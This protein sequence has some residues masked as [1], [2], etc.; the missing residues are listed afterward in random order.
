[1]ESKAAAAVAMFVDANNTDFNHLCLFGQD[2]GQMTRS[3]SAREGFGSAKVRVPPV[4]HGADGA[5][6]AAENH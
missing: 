6:P 2:S 5:C 1:M 3:K 4:R